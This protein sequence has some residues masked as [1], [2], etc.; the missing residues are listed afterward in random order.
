MTYVNVAV[1]GLAWYDLTALK[2]TLK[3][4]IVSVDAYSLLGQ[5]M[6][7]YKIFEV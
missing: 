2:N 1:W 7:A 3:V 6:P 4:R 5:Q